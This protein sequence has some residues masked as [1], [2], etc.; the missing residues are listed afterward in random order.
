MTRIRIAYE[1]RGHYRVLDR[2]VNRP[3]D[4]N[5]RNLFRGRLPAHRKEGQEKEMIYVLRLK[6]PMFPAGYIYD[7]A[8]KHAP[9]LL[10]RMFKN[11]PEWFVVVK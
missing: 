2:R 5:N 11:N 3:R 1:H 4:L 10:A 7:P 9:M 8:D 6:T